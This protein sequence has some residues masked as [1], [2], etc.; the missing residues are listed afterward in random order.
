VERVIV[1]GVDI[2]FGG[3]HS[4]FD[5]ILIFPRLNDA[6]IRADFIVALCAPRNIV[7]VGE[8]CVVEVRVSGTNRCSYCYE[9]CLPHT[10][11]ER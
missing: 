9:S 11:L 1:G 2:R 8:L 3:G 4:N 6:E 5:F 7:Y 10:R